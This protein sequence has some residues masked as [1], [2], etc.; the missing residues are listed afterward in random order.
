[1]TLSKSQQDD[2]QVFQQPKV[3][4]E[5]R[6]VWK[7]F[8]NRAH[9]LVDEFQAGD[10]SK[11]E[12]QKR[13]GCIVGVQNASFKV[14]E[15]EIF[16]IMGLSGSGKSTLVRLLNRLHDATHGEV[17]INGED[18][19][20]MSESQL[21]RLRAEKIGMVFQHISL[22]PHR[23]IQDNVTLPLEVRGKSRVERRKI[24]VQM[25]ELVGLDGWQN[26]MVHE[27]SGGMQQRV[28]LAR[29]LAADPDILLM[30][31]PFSA[32]DPLIRKQLQDEF[33]ALSRRTQK[34]T[35]FITHDLDEAIRIGHRIAIM[36]S[37]KIVQI[38]TAEEIVTQPAD[39]YVADFVSG[40]SRLKLVRARTIMAPLP[41]DMP[42]GIGQW[43]RAG[44]DCD[45]DHLT[46]IAVQSTDPIVIQDEDGLAVG[47]IDHSNLLRGIQGGQSIA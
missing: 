34:T 11:E 16:C 39:D 4:L 30:D 8:G 18:V 3:S 21:R 45:L 12:I 14:R 33:I 37:G 29:A 1:M 40:I 10:V 43:P 28:G 31:E 9:E 27:L 44:V 24:A 42:E 38:G 23:S 2:E 7:I 15:C 22:L 32:L 25:L 41:I 26:R 20:Q 6:N 46:N 13:T 35:I 47:L 36:K 17:L 5:L 19:M